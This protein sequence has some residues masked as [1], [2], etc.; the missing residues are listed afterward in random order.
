MK[1]YIWWMVGGAIVGWAA[2]N[3]LAGLF[4]AL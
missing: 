3:H 4:A 2:S 1:T